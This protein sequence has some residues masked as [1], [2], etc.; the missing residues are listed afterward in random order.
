MKLSSSKQ[1]ILAGVISFGYGCGQAEYA[2]VYTR[3]AFYSDW[4]SAIIMR[5]DVPNN[6]VTIAYDKVDNI[7]PDDSGF[8]ICS[9]YHPSPLLFILISICLSLYFV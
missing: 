7:F 3:V 6:P 8:N 4:V 1:W 9:R 2:G 5:Y